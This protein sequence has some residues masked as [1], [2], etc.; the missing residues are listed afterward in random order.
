M[1][2]RI[3][4]LIETRGREYLDKLLSGE[5]IITEKIDVFRI[6]FENKKGEIIFYKKDNTPITLIERTLNDTW[7]KALLEIPSIVDNVKIPE[8]IR[9]GIQYTPIERPL[10]IPYTNLP[11][12]ILSDVTKRHGK[13]KV[14]ESFDY[15]EVTKWAGMLCMARPPVI[16]SGKLNEEQKKKLIDYDTKNYNGDELSFSEMIDDM[17]GSTYSKQDIIEGIVIKSKDNKLVQVVS[18][19]FELLDEAY[20]NSNISRDFYDII[21]LSLNSFMEDYNLP[22][23]EFESKEEMYLNIVCDIF[24]KYCETNNVNE[25]ME[26]KYLTPPQYGHIGNLNKRFIKNKTT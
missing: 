24:N 15:K 18:Y 13:N 9:F 20:K 21:L 19:E 22:I 6:L 10:R 12:Y 16:F 25:T 1:L 5:V 7:E 2:K 8:G 26:I 23:L 14:V 4:E 11:R 17:F 3:S